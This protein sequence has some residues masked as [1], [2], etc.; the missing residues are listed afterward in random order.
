MHYG[1]LYWYKLSQVRK[2]LGACD[3]K[4]IN[5]KIMVFILYKNMQLSWLT[6]QSAHEVA[7]FCYWS[8][9]LLFLLSTNHSTQNCKQ[10]DFVVILCRSIIIKGRGGVFQKIWKFLCFNIF[11]SP[12]HGEPGRGTGNFLQN[13]KILNSWDMVR[14]SWVVRAGIFV[15][16]YREIQIFG[17]QKWPSISIHFWWVRAG[18]PNFWPG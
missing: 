5:L 10:T 7:A 14:Q 2:V 12:A 9:K 16:L 1:L 13:W 4:W 3:L 15:N 11:G 18:N 8:R 6:N 17:D